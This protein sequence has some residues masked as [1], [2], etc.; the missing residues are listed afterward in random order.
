MSK[1]HLACLLML[2]IISSAGAQTNPVYHRMVQNGWKY[3]FEKGFR[4]L[5]P[6]E[7]DA[8]FNSSMGYDSATVANLKKID[9]DTEEKAAALSDCI[10]IGTVSK[11]EHPSWPR[12]WYHTVAYV[13]VDEFLRNDYGL[14][15]G[16]VAVLEVSGP[17]GRPHEVMEQIGEDTLSAGEHV[18]LFL[19]ASGLITF[20]A[21]NNMR[22]LYN[23][24]INDSTVSF[25]KLAKYDIESGQ[26]LSKNKPLSTLFSLQDEIDTVLKVVHRNLPSSR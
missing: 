10:V 5:T 21:D 16:E 24:L 26:V 6:H 12:P 1:T 13:Q 20:A 8:E 14:P 3:P 9:V 7:V 23:Y 19:S 2:L 18:L 25:Q 22:D 15:K 17:T 11:I 4:K